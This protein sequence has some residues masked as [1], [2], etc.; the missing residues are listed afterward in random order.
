[1]N[2]RHDYQVEIYESPACFP[3][4][5]AKH[6]WFVVTEKGKKTRYEILMRRNIEDKLGYFHINF[7][8]PY[9]GLFILPIDIPFFFK[10]RKLGEIQG[11]SNSPA[12]KMAKFIKNS[13]NTY[14]YMH[15]YHL[16]GPNSNTYAQYVLNQ[17]PE[18]KIKLGITHIGRN[19]K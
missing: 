16:L 18:C 1:M 2:I 15:K 12:E 17:F 7:L 11:N 13:I 5:F 8:P 14:P 10:S 19:Y 6:T 9:S 4:S 3:A